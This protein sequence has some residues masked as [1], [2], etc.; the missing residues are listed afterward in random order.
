MV[1]KNS[2]CCSISA[3]WLLNHLISC[4]TK[5]QNGFLNEWMLDCLSDLLTLKLMSG[6]LLTDPLTHWFPAWLTFWLTDWLDDWLINLPVWLTAP[7]SDKLNSSKEEK[8]KVMYGL[9]DRLTGRLVDRWI[10]WPIDCLTRDWSTHVL[11]WR[12]LNTL[13]SSPNERCDL[14]VA[15]SLIFSRT[16]QPGVS[17]I[18][19][20]QSLWTAME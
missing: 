12:T 5:E 2:L 17:C 1:A 18:E 14:I 4:E 19:G 6:C 3:F 9:T 16:L 10:D 7:V 13:A 20:D 15:L 8:D 11:T